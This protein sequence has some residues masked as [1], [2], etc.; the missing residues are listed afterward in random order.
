MYLILYDS[1]DRLLCILSLLIYDLGLGLLCSMGG[2]LN[3]SYL[4]I[5]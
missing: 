2:Y 4:G 1:Y 5:R 3:L